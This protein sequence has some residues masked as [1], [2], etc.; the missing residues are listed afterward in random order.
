VN[1]RISDEAA[2]YHGL[3]RYPRRVEVARLERSRR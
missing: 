1:E 3:T 2:D